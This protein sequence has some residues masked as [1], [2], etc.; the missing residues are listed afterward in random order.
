MPVGFF[1]FIITQILKDWWYRLLSW[2]H[3][4]SDS[5]L[6]YESL[7]SN[8]T[9]RDSQI[10][11]RLCPS[12]AN[13]P[14]ALIHWE[15]HFT[16]KDQVLTVLVSDNPAFY[17]CPIWSH[18]SNVS[19][20]FTILSIALSC[21]FW[22]ECLFFPCLLRERLSSQ[23]RVP[24]S[25]ASVGITHTPLFFPYH[26]PFSPVIIL[27]IVGFVVYQKTIFLKFGLYIKYLYKHRYNFPC[28]WEKCLLKKEKQK[29]CLS[30]R[31]R[32]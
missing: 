1:I 5:M 18:F 10:L 11:S 3:S 20:F 17:T 16:F 22:M 21:F 30:K 6:W 26:T 2:W 23:E 24:I 19:W 12:D 31:A 9:P 14:N 15:H 32:S 4:C 27:R 13:W 7:F 25:L 8:K 29:Q 28:F